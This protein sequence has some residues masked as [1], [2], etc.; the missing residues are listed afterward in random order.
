MTRMKFAGSLGQM[1]SLTRSD[2]VLIIRKKKKSHKVDF[3][4]QEDHTVKI[5][6]IKNIDDYLARQLKKKT[7]LYRDTHLINIY[8]CDYFH[9]NHIFIIIIPNCSSVNCS[10]HCIL[11]LLNI[12]Q[13]PEYR[14][15]DWKNLLCHHFKWNKFIILLLIFNVLNII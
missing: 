3:A 1:H 6:E 14:R 15:K 12:E 7:F 11:S 8:C 4:F 5:K 10:I 13:N 9:N 2:L